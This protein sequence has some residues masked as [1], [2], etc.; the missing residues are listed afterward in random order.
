VRSLPIELFPLFSFSPFKQ[1]VSGID[2]N[3]FG[4]FI[5]HHAAL[6]SLLLYFSESV[7]WLKLLCS[8]CLLAIKRTRSFPLPGDSELVSTHKIRR[9]AVFA[10]ID[11]PDDHDLVFDARYDRIPSG[12]KLNVKPRAVDHDFVDP[13]ALVVSNQK[14]NR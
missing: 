6:R 12:R 9:P 4:V 5:R 14:Q 2:A 10:E 3:R 8:F 13:T 1:V 11:I 7:R